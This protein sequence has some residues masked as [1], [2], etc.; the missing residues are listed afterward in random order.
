MNDIGNEQ[1][2]AEKETGF[3]FPVDV[4]ACYRIGATRSGL[5]N[6]EALSN[7]SIRSTRERPADVPCIVP[8]ARRRILFVETGAR[9]RG[10]APC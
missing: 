7:E 8:A 6:S 9:R 1:S 2:P 10:I 3:V 5:L 4:A